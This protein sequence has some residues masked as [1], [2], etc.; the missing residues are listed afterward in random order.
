MFNRTLIRIK[1]IATLLFI[2]GLV[3]AAVAYA[4]NRSN[5][6]K[7]KPATGFTLVTRETIIPNFTGEPLELNYRVTTRHEKSDGTWKQV[8]SY[9]K[10][11]GKS[12]REDIAFGIPGEGVFQVDQNRGTLNFVSGMGPKEQTSY[13]AVTDDHLHPNFLKDDVVLGYATHVLRF[14]DQDGG[15]VDLYRAP[16]LNNRTIRKISVSSKGISVVDAVQ[17][18]VGNPEDKVFENLPM[19]HVRYERFQDKVKGMEEI[20]K[21]D[22]AE[23]MRQ[24]LKRQSKKD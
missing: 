4:V 19:W 12:F 8:R 18:T 15:Y 23:A 6:V 14:P 1:F 5:G 22:V 9:Y 17:I 7:L 24:E 10:S 3:S 20:G 2:V 16:D 11:E 21:P 13:V